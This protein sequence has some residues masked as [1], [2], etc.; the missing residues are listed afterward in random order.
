M[1]GELSL[2]VVNNCITTCILPNKVRVLLVIS[3]ALLDLN[4]ASFESL[5]QPHQAR[6]YGVV[7]NDVSGRHLATDKNKGCQNLVVGEKSLPLYFDGCK[8]Y[9]RIIRPT[10]DELKLLPRFVLT[11]ELPYLPHRYVV[12]RNL[13][14]NKIELLNKWR[15]QLGYPTYAA[16]NFTLNNTTQLVQSNQDDTREYMRNYF[17]KRVWTLKPRR[18]DDVLYSDTFF[19]S[20]QSIR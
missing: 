16:T 2:E 14:T 5:L 3:Q 7:V 4:P 12:A 8:C 20:V 11:S 19:S 1:K 6:A 9:F 15:R 13:R 10:S 17:K 18:I